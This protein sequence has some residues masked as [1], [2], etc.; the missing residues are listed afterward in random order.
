VFVLEAVSVM[1]QVGYFKASKG[2]RIFKCAPIHH[3]FHLSGWTENQVVVRFWL[4]SMI[5][6]AIALLTIKLR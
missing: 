5:L 6:A 3:H 4:A 2:K 1:M